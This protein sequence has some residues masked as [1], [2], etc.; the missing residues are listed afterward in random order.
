MFVS[1]VQVTGALLT[2]FVVAVPVCLGSAAS[3]QTRT[4]DDLRVELTL[5]DH[6]TVFRSGEPVR[7]VLS[8]TST[9]PY[10][11]SVRRPGNG[12]L[13]LGDGE[14]EITPETGVFHWA[15]RYCAT[16]YC[17]SDVELISILTDQAHREPFVFNDLVR[18]DRPGDY[19][20]RLT[21]SRISARRPA[22]VSAGGRITTNSVSFRVVP[23]TADEEQR[24]VEQIVATLQNENDDKARQELVERLAYLPGEAATRVRERGGF[25]EASGTTTTTGSTSRVIQRWR[26]DCWRPGCATRR[27][28]SPRG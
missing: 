27:C 21:T 4:A 19:T 15:R 7:L 3:S 25:S 18:F 17:G 6:K 28:R 20:V 9:V 2:A 12:A 14:I 11:Y 1:T 8:V 5:A 24:E 13:E 10:R 26:S 23:M 22:A 16:R